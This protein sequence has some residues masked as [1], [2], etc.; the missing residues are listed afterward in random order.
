MF[1]VI[2]RTRLAADST[3]DMQEAAR[4]IERD[5]VPRFSQIPGF[6]AY[7]VVD[8]GND[9]LA[10][11]S[12]FKNRDAVEETTRIAREWAAENRDKFGSITFDVAAGEVTVHKTAGTGATSNIFTSTTRETGTQ[13]NA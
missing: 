1:A 7:Y 13:L 2:R 9:E 11:I 12:V 4:L 6:E 5:I 3:I 10:T 8:L